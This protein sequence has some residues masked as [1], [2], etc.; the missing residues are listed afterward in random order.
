MKII[1]L[2]SAGIIIGILAGLLAG[3]LIA[4]ERGDDTRRKISYQIRRLLIKR[5]STGETLPEID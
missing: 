4:P 3:L 1:I 5:N 2:L